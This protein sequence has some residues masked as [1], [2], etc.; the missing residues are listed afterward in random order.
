MDPLSVTASVVGLLAT[1]TKLV[2]QLYSLG[3]II[4]DAPRLAQA[5]ATELEAIAFVLTPLQTYI[6]GYAQASVARLSL[7][8]VE[9]ITATLTGCVLTYS[10]LDAVLKS[11]RSNTK[12]TA[13]DR[14]KWY[15]KSDEVQPLITRLQG[16]KASFT[17]ML[18][19][20][21]W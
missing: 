6:D 5:A 4:K 3:T 13:W 11:M 7:I 12:M 19:I 2:P 15:V 18:N 16:H 21:Q 20:V 10:E 8:T 9:H 1:T 14:T 17:L